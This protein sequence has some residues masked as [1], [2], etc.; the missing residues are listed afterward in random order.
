MGALASGNVRV[1]NDDV[2][3][4][5]RIQPAAIDAVAAREQKELERQE[6]EYRT[7]R[8]PPS[9]EH[10]IVIL[11]DDGLATGAT[12]RA[13]VKALRSH[14][15]RHLVVAAPVGAAETCQ[16][17]E[18]EADEVVCAIA[19]HAFGAVGR[20]Y[21]DFGPTSDEEVKALLHESSSPG[22]VVQT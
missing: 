13:A 1:L 11:I 15:P 4:Q 9:L 14:R 16:D 7:D 2:V 20:W 17:F 21:E 10:K 18:K 3:R 12:M 8:E 6:N 22:N 19:P 5:L